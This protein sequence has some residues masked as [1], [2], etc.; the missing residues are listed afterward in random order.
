MHLLG[1]HG[2]WLDIFHGRDGVKEMVRRY[3]ETN[4]VLI[5]IVG[6]IETENAQADIF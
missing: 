3:D 4:P 1:R 5:E 2:N 6:N